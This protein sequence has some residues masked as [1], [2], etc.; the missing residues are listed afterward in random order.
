MSHQSAAGH[1]RDA[2]VGRASAPSV[3][4]ARALR[5]RSGL[6]LTPREESRIFFSGAGRCI[7]TI[8]EPALRSRSDEWVYIMSSLSRTLYTGV[9]NHL[10]RRAGEHKEAATASFTALG[11]TQWSR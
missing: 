3:I 5:L 4:L 8:M 1:S 11:G 2:V 7:S 10:E 9:T 6:R